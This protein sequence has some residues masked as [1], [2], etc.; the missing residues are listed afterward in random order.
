MNS[1]TKTELSESTLTREE[2]FGKAVGSKFYLAALIT[3]GAV[4]LF[5]AA[6]VIYNLISAIILFVNPE[7]TM[8]DIG[9]TRVS[10]IIS[11]GFG[12]IMT[13]L[14]DALMPVAMIFTLVYMIKL[15][16]DK[17]SITPEGVRQ[18]GHGAG[19]LHLYSIL[20]LI[21]NAFIA[22]F[23]FLPA[24]KLPFSA[25]AAADATVFEQV[26]TFLDTPSVY[27]TLFSWLEGSEN[28]F[29]SV[30]LAF[31]TGALFLAFAFVQL[32]T[33]G[34]FKNYFKDVEISLENK[35]YIIEKKAPLIVPCIF[36]GANALVAIFVLIS[37]SWLTALSSLAISAFT[38]AT[39][40]LLKKLEAEKLGVVDEEE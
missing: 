32:M 9:G 7:M 29:A 26:F 40:L 18:L 11:G 31:I 34:F 1:Q 3:V 30:A 2:K 21:D 17:N 20:M 39:S 36:A 8:A 14:L 27:T 16:R 13:A 12:A 24:F 33:F 37:G 15:I 22:F 25:R 38:V 5:T 23:L 10:G 4:A 28:G 6:S 35:N 19:V